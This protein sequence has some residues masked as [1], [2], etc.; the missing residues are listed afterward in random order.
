MRTIA[1][2]VASLWLGACATMVTNYLGP[3]LDEE[4]QV[5]CAAAC[6]QAS[7]VVLQ[8]GLD[9]SALICK[10]LQEEMEAIIS[11]SI[12]GVRVTKIQTPGLQPKRFPDGDEV[13]LRG[14]PASRGLSSINR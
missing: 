2:M 9:V 8:Q 3:V 11:K 7:R 5:A 1:L 10:R 13:G 12:P 14:F 4:A 6:D